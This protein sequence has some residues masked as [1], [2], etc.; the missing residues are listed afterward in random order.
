ME[1]CMENAIGGDEA[2][3]PMT[4][5][6][7]P[8]R[9]MIL[10]GE[11]SGDV[12]GAR[13]AAGIRDR[14]PG[15]EM[16]GLGGERMRAAGVR[17]LAGLDQ[18]AVM[19]FVEVLKRL[20]FFRSL[21]RRLKD[22]LDG[23]GLDLVLPVDYPGLNLRI[24]GHAANRGIPVVYYIGPQVGAWRA[25][26]ARKLSRVANR[27]AVIL[28]FEPELYRA[29]GGRA[30]FVG[31]PLLEDES[32]GDPESLAADLGLDTVRPV[33]AVFPG[34]RE[35]E[36]VR[37]AEPFVNT[38]LELER[39]VPGLQ[40]VVSKVPFLPRSAYR[41]FPFPLT[42]DGPSLRA[43]ATAGLVKSGTGTLEAALSGMPFA[44]AYRTHP[45]T[46]FLARRL[47]RV[48][49]ISLANLVAEERVVPEF[50]QGEAAP[51]PMAD[52][53]EPLLHTE[54]PVRR[55]TLAGLARV[56]SALGSRGASSRVVDLMEDVLRE[57]R[58][59]EVRA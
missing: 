28:P 45:V 36:L 10:A 4:R 46:H 6:S 44:V 18:L 17:L 33:L 7:C 22:M 11:A 16:V 49:H 8:R 26:R 25:G 3:N 24:A 34:S 30:E 5:T 38:A 57:T 56:R 50:I 52:A 20:P 29:H 15:V 58:C 39:R 42:E 59:R 12:H 51:G 31:H 55:R 27:I 1:D 40:A 35:Q 54:S 32:P 21:E 48:P 9:V 41:P 23:G 14:W 37:H 13:V 53:I 19:G 43:L 2:G 47:V